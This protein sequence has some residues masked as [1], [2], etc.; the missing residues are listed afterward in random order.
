MHAHWK[1]LTWEG[2]G[3]CEGGTYG[4]DAGSWQTELEALNAHF[5][6][7]DVEMQQMLRKKVQSLYCPESSTHCTPPVKIKSRLT[8]EQKKSRTPIGSTKRDPSGFEHV[9]K[10]IADQQKASQRRQPKKEKGVKTDVKKKGKEESPY[11]CHFPLYQHQYVQEVVDVVADGNC[12]YRAVAAQ[13]HAAGEAAWP[14]VR[15][16]LIQEIYEHMDLYNVMFGDDVTNELLERLSLGPNEHPAPVK[17]WM[18][19]P[20][21]GYLIANRF[22]VVFVSLS[23]NSNYTYLPCVGEGPPKERP[24]QLVVVGH[25]MDCHYVQ[26]CED[27]QFM[28]IICCNRL[29]CNLVV[30]WSLQLRLTPG[31]PMPEIAPCWRKWSAGDLKKWRKPYVQRLHQ[32]EVDMTAWRYATHGA[33]WSEHIDLGD[34]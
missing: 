16:E 5:N 33:P 22:Q 11:M 24:H 18:Q 7:V 26:V 15:Q 14:W 25:V 21:M 28:S 30:F 10:D 20:E 29:L 4:T 13:V 9:D 12:G 17:K 23:V 34:D 19:L 27:Y 1:S 8:P 31:H 32:F 3:S 6:S 2:V